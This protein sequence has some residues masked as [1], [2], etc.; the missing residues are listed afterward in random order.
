MYLSNKCPFVSEEA[1]N[2]TKNTKVMFCAVVNRY[3]PRFNSLFIY[4]ISTI[5]TADEISVIITCLYLWYYNLTYASQ[6]DE[7]DDEEAEDKENKSESSSS[8]SSSEDTSDS[9][10]EWEAVLAERAHRLPQSMWTEP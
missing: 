4:I 2:Y 9:E 7:D 8:A 10:S 5:C 1:A 3:N 6:N